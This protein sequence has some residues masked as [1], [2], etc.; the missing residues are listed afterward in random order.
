MVKACSVCREEK[1]NTEQFFSKH[2]PSPNGLRPNCKK[3]QS[4]Y[5]TEYTKIHSEEKRV[6]ESKK[7]SQWRY[8]VDKDKLIELQNFRCA[9]SMCGENIASAGHVD[10]DHS[11][12]SGK[13]SCGKCVRGLLCQN[14]NRAL[15]MF[16]ESIL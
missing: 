6:R 12:C 8:K 16:L 13:K 4:I 1:P 14:C 3:C 9:N 15:G 11:C 2:K 10:H 7:R 5:S